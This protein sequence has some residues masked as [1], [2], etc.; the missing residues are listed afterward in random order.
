[1][2]LNTVTRGI[3]HDA[4]PRIGMG[5]F[6]KPSEHVQERK[7]SKEGHSTSR[8]DVR[9]QA[10]L[11]SPSLISALSC[12][13]CNPGPQLY[14]PV[15]GVKSQLMNC[16]GLQ[17]LSTGLGAQSLCSAPGFI[18]ETLHRDLE[19]CF[20]LK[21]VVDIQCSGRKIAVLGSGGW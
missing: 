2:A 21:L 3:V 19:S 10:C 1:M 20:G 16:P 9:K 11:G 18:A 15:Q 5:L 7:H 13:V 4:L 8:S 12:N 6:K 17:V 14:A